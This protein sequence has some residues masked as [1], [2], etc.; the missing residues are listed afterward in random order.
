MPNAEEKKYIGTK[1]E[2]ELEFGKVMPTTQLEF[3]EIAE[4]IIREKQVQAIVLGCTELPLIF[5][6]VELSVSYIN[7]MQVHINALVDLIMQG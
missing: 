4:C 7:V 1:I 2:T 3:K 6:D 5:K